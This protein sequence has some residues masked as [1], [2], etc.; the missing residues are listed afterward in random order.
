VGPL[1]S[2][3]R[4]QS[5]ELGQVS[6]ELAKRLMSLNSEHD[7]MVSDEIKRLKDTFGSERFEVLNNGI[8]HFME[9]AGRSVEITAK[10]S[11]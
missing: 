10:D 2:E 4:F 8:D 3:A 9:V 5:I 7:Q 1:R 6:E 11:K